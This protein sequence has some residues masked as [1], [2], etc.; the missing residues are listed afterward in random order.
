MLDSEQ[1][2]YK[3]WFLFEQLEVYQQQ[4]KKEKR[5]TFKHSIIRIQN[6]SQ[7]STCIKCYE[8]TAKGTINSS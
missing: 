3:I 8:N 5:K 4:K 7:I 6:R 2:M 1:K